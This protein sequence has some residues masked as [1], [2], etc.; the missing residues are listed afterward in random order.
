MLRFFLSIVYLV[1]R[2]AVLSLSDNFTLAQNIKTSES[3]K[4]SLGAKLDSQMHQLAA[5]GISGVLF[6]AKD[7]QIV[8]NQGYGLVNKENKTP[9]FAGTVFDIG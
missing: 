3:V 1:A 7:G 5:K 8:L 6:V 4:S 9:Y 2:I